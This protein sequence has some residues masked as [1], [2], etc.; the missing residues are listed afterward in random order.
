MYYTD[1]GINAV[2]AVNGVDNPYKK[3]KK[4]GLNELALALGV[5]LT[6]LRKMSESDL[7]KLAD[8]KGVNLNDY[9][10]PGEGPPEITKAMSMSG[11]IFNVK[12][13]EF[14]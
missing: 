6:D 8:K 5:T 1:G 3:R 13:P 7:K 4:G 9:Q 2:G 14:Y 12:R 10:K 11:S